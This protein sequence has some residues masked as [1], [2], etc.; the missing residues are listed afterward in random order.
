MDAI[1]IVDDRQDMRETVARIIRLDLVE[2]GLD[3]NVIPVSPFEN[4]TD[5]AAWIQE[6]SVCVIVLDENLSE[7]FEISAVNYSGHALASILRKQKPDLPQFIVT[8]VVE[9]NDLDA[10]AGDLEDVI[11][12]NEFHINSKKYVQRMVRAGQSFVNRYEAELDELNRV[13][14]AIV[15]DTATETDLRHANAIRAKLQIAY[16]LETAMDLKSWLESAEKTAS[17][18]EQVVGE[19]KTIHPKN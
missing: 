1:A 12:R 19:L 3:W 14:T 8:S 9:H 6:H 2:L 16:D 15:T 18:L 5:Y 4:P 10:A 17:A 11:A 7:E 13:A